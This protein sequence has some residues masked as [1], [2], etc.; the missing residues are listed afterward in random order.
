[1]Q[2]N[3]RSIFNKL[4]ELKHYLS[5]LEKL[6]DLICLQ[7]TFLSL[8]YNPSIPRYCLLHKD[9]TQGRGGGICILLNLILFI[10]IYQ[11]LT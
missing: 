8:R 7:E 4:P 11:N 5:T 1:M 10:A 9:R 3:C 6:P 2:W